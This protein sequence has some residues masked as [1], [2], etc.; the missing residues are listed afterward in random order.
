MQLKQAHL[1]LQKKTAIVKKKTWPKQLLGF[2]LLA[3]MH[4]DAQLI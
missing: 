4:P 3:S 2:L 1:F